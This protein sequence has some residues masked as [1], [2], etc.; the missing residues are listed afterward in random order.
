MTVKNIIDVIDTSS[1]NIIMI[2]CDSLREELIE[3]EKGKYDVGVFWS[4][5]KC[6]ITTITVKGDKLVIGV[7]LKGN[8]FVR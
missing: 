5:R 1:T 2:P 8:T 6:K 4:I 3:Y 7:E